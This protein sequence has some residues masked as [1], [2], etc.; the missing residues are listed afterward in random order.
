MSIDPKDL[1]KK[2]MDRNDLYLYTLRKM[3]ESNLDNN[4]TNLTKLLNKRAFFYKTADIVA[5]NYDNV[6]NYICNNYVKLKPSLVLNLGDE[7]LASY[8][9]GSG[10]GGLVE[11]LSLGKHENPYLFA[12][13]MGKYDR[14]PDLLLGMTSVAARADVDFYG[15][16]EFGG[17]IALHE[18]NGLL[19]IIE[20]FFLNLFGKLFIFFSSFHGNVTSLW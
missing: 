15:L 19:G 7:L 8:I 5:Q 6:C 4:L 2:E 12:R 18:G 10:V 14:T 13:A 17:G 9:V 3:A 16:I 1:S 20:L 11:L